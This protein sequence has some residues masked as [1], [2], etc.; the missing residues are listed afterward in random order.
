MA[1]FTDSTINDWLN[2]ALAPLGPAQRRFLFRDIA[3][4][5]QKSQSDRIAAQ[6][7]PDGSAFEARKPRQKQKGIRQ[8]AMFARI[9]TRKHFKYRS[10]A[11][12]AAVG[13]TGRI[14]EIA[15]VHQLGLVAEV[16]KGGPL[17]KYARRELLGLSDADMSAIETI[18][19][20][21]LTQR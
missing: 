11:N 12:E 10:S 5:L 8:R 1:E 20:K 9:R 15:K 2:A 16:E 18:T 13:F 7:N 21:H 17:V 3:R 14:A 4:Y 6:K 19:N